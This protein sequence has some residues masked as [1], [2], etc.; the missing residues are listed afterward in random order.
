[1]ISES[2]IHFKWSA[3]IH[4]QMLPLTV[5]EEVEHG[6][7]VLDSIV[8][9]QVIQELEVCAQD[10][11]RGALEPAIIE[12]KKALFDVAGAFGINLHF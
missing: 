6:E 11:K 2:N 3:G 4:N 7:T 10:E 8:V 9:D 12:T 5:L 1:M